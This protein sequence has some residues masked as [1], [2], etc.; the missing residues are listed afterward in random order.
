[1]N[2]PSL[3]R[4]QRRQ[5][6]R[7]A[8]K[9]GVSPRA[10]LTLGVAAL[11]AASQAQAATF[12]VTN[13]ADSGAG[14]LRQALTDANNA[15]GADVVSFQAGL[16]G[17]ITLT[18]GQLEILDSVDVQGP[19]AATLT[20]SGNNA[21]R[22]FYLYNKG[23]LIDV[24]ISGLTITGGVDD[25]AGG[26]VVDFGE[27]LTLDSVV[28]TG[29]SAPLGAGLAANG[30]DMAVTVRD[31]TITGNVSGQDGGGI[32][33]YR[34]GGPL[35]IDGTTISNN[36]A[37]HYGGGLFV[38]ANAGPVT[39]DHSTIS[40]NTAAGLGGGAFFY[41]TAGGS[42]TFDHSTVSGNTADAGGGIGTLFPYDPISVESSTVSG[43]QAL[44]GVGGGIYAY[45]AGGGLSVE[46]STVANNSAGY[47][48]GGI[49][50]AIG[51]T[52]LDHALVGD[53]TAAEGGADLVNG[54][55]SFTATFSL[56]EDTTDPTLVDGGGN[57]FNQDPQLGPLGNHGG[58]TQTQVP[59]GTSPAVNA[60]NPA[61]VPPPATDQRDGARV[62]GGRIDIGA[63]ELNAGTISLTTATTSVAENAGTVTIT[64]N[65]T[66]G[67]DGAVSVTIATANGTAVAPGDYT[68]A[69]TTLTWADGDTAPKTLNVTIVNDT[70]PEGDETFSVTISAP[71]G[72]ATVG[73]IA[74]EVVTI[75]TDPADSQISVTEV[76]TLGEYGQI[77]LGT[78]LGAGGLLLLRRRKGLA[79][80]V[81][82]AT[83][84]LGAAG[85]ADAAQ[86]SWM[87]QTAKPP[88]AE[89]KATTLAQLSV[90]NGMVTV[91][92]GDGSTVQVPEAQFRLIDRR[93]GKG[94]HYRPLAAGA[95]VPADQPIVLKMRDR[96]DGSV[97]RVRVE[98][99]DTVA[100]AAR[101]A[102]ERHRS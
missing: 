17:T 21:S 45:Y 28:I 96:R 83:L 87:Q 59:A 70:E 63:V 84:T 24:T 18:T 50:V 82:I 25:N 42:V 8:G 73:P 76:P 14:S 91:R 58:P 31:S 53:N 80:P 101:A 47:L 88:A 9:D 27:N 41:G 29:N 78:L 52:V 30:D 6:D 54:S 51:D 67:S 39:V 90:Q 60:G 34:I 16:S 75:L 55:G 65:R 26:G 22:V 66:G 81:V 86:H 93:S 36:Q 33:V 64:A 38:Y 95:A 12:N 40:G 23:S 20:V 77:L 102:A 79:A 15:A 4:Q 3:S 46:H 98:L 99:F 100:D 57:V 13:L 5:L 72:G 49:A 48:G 97:R 37:A 68:G 11:A 56:V 94:H 10:A 44:T 32:Y 1:M 61:F 7:K 35:L 89:W 71:T 43:N 2:E 19:G 69:T 85:A 92:L 62:A 74:T